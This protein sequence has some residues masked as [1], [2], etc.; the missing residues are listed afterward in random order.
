M[1]TITITIYR[2]LRQG[3]TKPYLAKA[4][5]RD[6]KIKRADY[7]FNTLKEL[8]D[9]YGVT[10]TV[11]VDTGWAISSNG[12]RHEWNVYEAEISSSYKI[13]REF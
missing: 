5:N 12:K 1:D 7:P 3:G 4:K 11:K 8:K 10:K 2:Y 6:I 13:L 9:Y